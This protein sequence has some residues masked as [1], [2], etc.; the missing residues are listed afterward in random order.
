MSVDRRAIVELGD[1]A[2]ELRAPGT[3]EELAHVPEPLIVTRLNNH[4]ALDDATMTRLVDDLGAACAPSRS[5]SST[6][7]SACVSN[8]SRPR[9]TS[10]SPIPTSDRSWPSPRPITAPPSP[11][12]QR[13]PP[14]IPRLPWRW[15]SCCASAPGRTWPQGSPPSPSCTRRCRP[16]RS[17]LPGS[18]PGAPQRCRPT[19]SLRSCSHA[20][21]GISPSRSTA[22]TGRTPSPLRCETPWSRR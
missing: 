19:P 20:R 4:A 13:V 21:T 1:L 17:S 14:P 8:T 11:P 22:R 12:S 6:S 18:P 2:A 9:S 3:L 10:C 15:H 5:R 16:A 7:P